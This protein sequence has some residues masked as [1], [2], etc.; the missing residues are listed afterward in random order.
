MKLDIEI[1]DSNLKKALEELAKRYPQATRQGMIN[2]AFM[3]HEDATWNCPVDTGRLRSSLCVAT[4][5]EV[6]KDNKPHSPE[7]VITPPKS[8]FEVYVG[9]RVFYAPYIE[10][11]TRKMRAR[12][13]LRPAFQKNIDKLID[14]I[15]K[16]AQN[17]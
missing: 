7:D 8:E 3:I 10:F 17:G 9:T 2:T 5:G 1:E 12:P 4:K 6:I 11:G 13:Y 15:K 14:E 16:E